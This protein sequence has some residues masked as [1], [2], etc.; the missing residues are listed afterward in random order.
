MIGQWTHTETREHGKATPG[1][2]GGELP[3]GPP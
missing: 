2:V 1:Q 3:Y